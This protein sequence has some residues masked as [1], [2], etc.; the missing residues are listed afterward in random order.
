MGT[1]FIHTSDEIPPHRVRPPRHQVGPAASSRGADE[2]EIRLRS[3]CQTAAAA[4]MVCGLRR[5]C[6]GR[7]GAATSVM[8]PQNLDATVSAFLSH[9][10]RAV[11]A[12]STGVG[13]L[14]VASCT[15]GVAD[16]RGG[17]VPAAV[18]DSADGGGHAE[19]SR[20]AAAPRPCPARAQPRPPPPGAR[21]CRRLRG[22]HAAG[23]RRACMSCMLWAHPDQP[24]LRLPSRGRR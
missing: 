10:G 9:V 5:S 22:V 19:T 13:G 23:P 11:A 17:G 24:R 15:G 2:P 7:R 12:R 4:R 1:R 21:L 6:L 18:G 20:R 8:N 16:P 3:G 14:R